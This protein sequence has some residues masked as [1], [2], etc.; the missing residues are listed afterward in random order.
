MLKSSPISIG[1][2]SPLPSE[3]FFNFRS[4]TFKILSHNNLSFYVLFIKTFINLL[5]LLIL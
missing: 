5:I 2:K 1:I 3:N 4:Y